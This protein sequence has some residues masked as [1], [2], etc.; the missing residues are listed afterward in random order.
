MV[1]ARVPA[2]DRFLAAVF[3]RVSSTQ[4]S[5][6]FSAR[7]FVTPSL[8]VGSLKIGVQDR[9]PSLLLLREKLEVGPH[10]IVRC[11]VAVAVMIAVSRPVLPDVCACLHVSA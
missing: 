11:H 1:S 2:A 8:C 7:G 10:L 4:A 6:T 9:G 5:W 3:L